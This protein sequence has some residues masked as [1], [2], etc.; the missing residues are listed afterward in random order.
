[1]GGI[2]EESK[3]LN[4]QVR[5]ILISAYEFENNPVF[6]NYVKGGIINSYIEKP[7]KINRLRQRVRDELD[8]N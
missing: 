5:T 7:V 1:M 4:P 8:V 2:T 6:Q 3:K